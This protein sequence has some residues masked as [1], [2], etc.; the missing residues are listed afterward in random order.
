MPD[1]SVSG[2][3]YLRELKRGKAWYAKLRYYP[4]RHDRRVKLGDAWTRKDAPPDGWLTKRSAE[5]ALQELL[6]EER[7]KLGETIR[8]GARVSFSDA[9]NEWLR[10]T[11]VERGRRS[12]TMA[13]YRNAV[14]KVLVPEFGASTPLELVHAEFIER[15]KAEW[16]GR[17]TPRTVNKYL[18]MLHGIMARAIKLGWLRDNP[19]DRVD[20]LPQKRE[21]RFQHL[22]PAEVEALARAADD[23]HAAIYVTAAF[24]G[25]RQGEL[26][27]LR[28]EDVSFEKH[29]IHVRRETKSGY[30]RSVPLID[31]VARELD[32]LS[33]REHWTAPGD[34]VFPNAVGRPFDPSK[35]IRQLHKDLAAAKLARVRF[36]DLRH[37]FGTLAVRKFPLT[38]VKAMM[39]HADIQTTM[40]YI[41]HVPQAEAAA[42]LAE[43][44]ATDQLEEVTDGT[45]QSV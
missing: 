1:H 12:S 10:W 28:W 2:H 39:G 29:L 37:T 34:L 8:M 3:C 44:M 13:D 5:A 32:A 24:T 38:D 35:L 9:C 17:L 11:E 4:S 31:R 26:R 22:E 33:R 36:H 18:I 42:K 40:R 19:L 15:A 45:R 16:M 27:Q 43:A 7:R 21:N 20:R 41:H 30:A 23:W 25:L 6:V 14:D